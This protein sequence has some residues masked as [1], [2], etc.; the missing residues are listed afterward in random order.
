MKDLLRGR[1]NLGKDMKKTPSLK[2]VQW[3][4]AI[5]SIV[6]SSTAHAQWVTWPVS[7]GGNGHSYLAVPGTPGLTW[8]IASNAAV[9]Q[10]GTLATITSP[11]EDAFVFNLINA[12]QF[13]TAANGSGPAIGGFQLIG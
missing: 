2:I 8:T 7:A 11:A 3:L 9:L 13:F 12:P 10:G 6:F 4:G 1:D 5:V